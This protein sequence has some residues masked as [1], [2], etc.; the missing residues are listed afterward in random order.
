MASVKPIPDGHNSVSPYL[1]VD[2]AARAIE[3]YKTAFGAEEVFRLTEP[4]GKIGHAELQIRGSRL[5]LA[6]EYPDFGALGPASVG[7]SPV[8][9][10][11]YVEDGR[12]GAP[13]GQGRVLRR[14]HRDDRGSIRPQVADRDTRGR[15]VPGGDAAALECDPRL[16]SAPSQKKKVS[17]L[18]ARRYHPAS[19]DGVSTR[20]CPYWVR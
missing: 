7:G 9:I 17:A 16:I 11:L 6:D 20:V 1:I 2:G 10:H 15:R 18:M 5:M 14:P 8:S 4:Q 19:P 13:A 12:N 3:F